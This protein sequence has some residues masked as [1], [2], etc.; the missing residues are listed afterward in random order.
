MAVPVPANRRE[1]VGVRV[2]VE[3]ILGE[4]DGDF[5]AVIVRDVVVDPDI[6]KVLEWDGVIRV[7]KDAVTVTVPQVVARG[8]ADGMNDTIVV[9]DIE[10]VDFA[11]KVLATDALGVTV[12]DPDAVLVIVFKFEGV[13]MLDLEPAVEGDGDVDG[14]REA[15][16][17]DDNV[18][19]VDTFEDC[20]GNVD[21]EIVVELLGVREFKEDPVPDFVAVFEDAV[22]AVADWLREKADAVTVGLTRIVADTLGDGDVVGDAVVEVEKEKVGDIDVVR[23][24][25]F[26]R[27]VLP[28][29]DGDLNK[30]ADN[31]ALW[32]DDIV[33]CIDRVEE[34]EE[35]T[36][37][38]GL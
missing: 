30:L 3:E 17:F 10:L 14:A 16:I 24:A 29:V 22:V 11:E 19:E 21:D 4:A 7:E 15:E 35:L 26:V 5:E 32:V 37:I 13:R 9:G 8:D 33:G 18:P 36:R 27:E 34:G 31:F 2:G 25:D 12:P 28:E 23:C 1:A 38:V 20:V 6:V